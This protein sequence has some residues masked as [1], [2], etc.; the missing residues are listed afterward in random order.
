MTSYTTQQRIAIHIVPNISQSK[1]N[2]RIK[3]DQL[4]ESRTSLMQYNKGKNFSSDIMHKMR[5]GD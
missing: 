3:F 1:D 4:M 5:Q 2:E